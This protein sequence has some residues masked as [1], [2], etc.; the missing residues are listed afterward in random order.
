ML[1][2]TLH[3]DIADIDAQAWDALLKNSERPTPFMRHAYLHG[4]QIS[5]SAT[6]ET[7]WLARFA[8]LSEAPEEQDGTDTLLA[9]CPV[10]IKNHSYGEYI[11]DWSWAQAYQQHG[12]A[13][14]PKAVVAVPFTPV[15]G[16]RIL[17]AEE[18]HRRL[19]VQHLTQHLAAHD[20]SSLHILWGTEADT[21]HALESEALALEDNI[22][23][24][25]PKKSSWA[26]REQVQFH[27]HNANYASFDDFLRSLQQKKRKQIKAERRK[28]AHAG[29][30]WRHKQGRD[31]TSDDWAFFYRCYRQT[32]WE[33]GNAPYLTPAFFD[34]MQQH[35]AE[36]WLLCIAYRG[37]NETPIACSLVALNPEQRVAYGRY[38][39]TLERV[40]CLHFDACYY[41]P[42]AW[43]I[44]HGYLRFE[45]GAQGEHKM[46][47]GLSPSAWQ[48]AHW[49]A[50]P[51]FAAAIQ[52]YTVQERQHTQ[53]Y[54]LHLEQR[55]PYKA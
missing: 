6:A 44:E 29:V 28:V 25:E 32:Y 3:E 15:P 55:T 39:G 42:I 19:L 13:Y 20:V 26:L 45:G 23:D 49:I 16:S 38:W 7:G 17:G 21:A 46:A 4:L 1:H 22:S 41:Q 34:H 36:N 30:R 24:R 47:R 48:S 2:F 43:C 11:F 9:A 27:W 53:A 54:H 8:T 10:Y 35:M 5:E 51:E 12:L 50:H 52:R 33:H 40:D 37:E 14:Y 31:I 18:A